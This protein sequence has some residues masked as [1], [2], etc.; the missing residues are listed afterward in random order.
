MK[1]VK[2]ISTPKTAED[3]WWWTIGGIVGGLLIDNL[4]VDTGKD[5]FAK[6]TPA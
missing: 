3:A 5:I 4:I 2:C 1:H 6:V